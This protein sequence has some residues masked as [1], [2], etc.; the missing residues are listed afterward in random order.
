MTID[1]DKV[2]KKYEGLSGTELA[3]SESQER[4]AV[5]VDEK[6]AE[7]FIALAAEENL[8]ATPVAAVTDTGRM[9]MLSRVGR[10][11]IFPANFSIPTA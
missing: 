11:W 10:S 2:P 7:A 9:K 8:A 1:L 5:V 3:I 4:M 6:D